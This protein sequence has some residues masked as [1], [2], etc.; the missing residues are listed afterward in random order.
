MKPAVLVVPEKIR[1]RR[2][3][4]KEKGAHIDAALEFQVKVPERAGIVVGDELVEFLK[5]LVAYIIL[6]LAPQRLDLVNLNATHKNRKRDKVRIL[7]DDLADAILFGKPDMLF[8]QMERNGSADLIALDFLDS[9]CSFAR[10]GPLVTTLSSPAAL[11]STSISS[12]TIN[13]A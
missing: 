5:F 4:H 10:G 7:L 9:E 2:G 11:V 13:A 8:R 12:A 1:R 6:L 3:R